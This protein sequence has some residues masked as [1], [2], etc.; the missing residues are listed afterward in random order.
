MLAQRPPASTFNA[1]AVM[2]RLRRVLR[3]QRIG[4]PGTILISPGFV[5]FLKD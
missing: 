1:N 3:Q 4:W 2:A 5:A